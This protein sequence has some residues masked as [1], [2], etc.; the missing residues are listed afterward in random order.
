MALVQNCDRVAIAPQFLGEIPKA[1]MPKA[2]TIAFLVAAAISLVDHNDSARAQAQPCRSREY[3]HNAYTICEVDLGKHTVRLYWKRSDGTPYAYL[4]SLPRV[5]EHETGR[6]LF[7][8]NAGM[9]DPALKPVGLYVEQGRELVHANT[10]SGYGNFHMKPNGIFYI[11]AGRAAVAETQAF[12]KQRPQADVATQSGPMLV[13]N[14][15]LH[16][17]FDRGSTSLKARNG[18]GVRADGKVIFAISQREVSFDAFARLFRDGLNCPNALFLDGGSA[19]SLYAP[20]LANHG[21]I[22]SLGPMLAVFERDR[23]ASRQ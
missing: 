8:T 15:R 6:L 2:R 1:D 17:R 4:S 10:K 18:V 22:L 11:A 13:I 5:L 16:P 19:S 23:G 20:S 9:F 21:N 3:A 12:V 14:G 7:A